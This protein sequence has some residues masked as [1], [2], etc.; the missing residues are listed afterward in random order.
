M[1]QAVAPILV[2]VHLL[3][4]PESPR[5]LV[6]RDRPEEALRILAREHA[7]GHEDDELVR[8]E[9]DEIC[10]ALRMEKEN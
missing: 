8:Y 1:F 2:L 9:Y 5:W 4:V 10:R 6:D 7:H 3:F